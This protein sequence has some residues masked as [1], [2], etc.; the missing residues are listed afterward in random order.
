MTW[1][2]VPEHRNLQGDGDGDGEDPRKMPL[3]RLRDLFGGQQP[4]EA[5]ADPFAGLTDPSGLDEGAMATH[6]MYRALTA[7]G[8]FTAVE[9]LYYQAC[10]VQV[11][12]AIQQGGLIPPPEGQ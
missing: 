5:G 12:I 11:G 6:E 4:P 3:D 10:L 2:G 8:R 1:D 7:P 9:A